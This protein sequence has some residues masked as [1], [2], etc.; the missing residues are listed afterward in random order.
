MGI[1]NDGHDRVSVKDGTVFCCFGE[2]TA[3]LFRD[4]AHSRF[5]RLR[6][7]GAV[8]MSCQCDHTEVSRSSFGADPQAV[9][10]RGHHNRIIRNHGFDAEFIG[11]GVS[12]DHNVIAKNTGFRS[13]R[14]DIVVF[15]DSHDNVVAGNTLTEVGGHP[16]YLGIW[17]R[18]D[19]DT[20][21]A[22]DHTAIRRNV[23]AGNAI[24]CPLSGR[25]E[26]PFAGDGIQ[27]DLGSTATL[28]IANRVFANEGDGID[29]EAVETR[30]IGN[31][32]NDNGDL[33]IEAVPGVFGRANRASANGNPLQC[34]NVVCR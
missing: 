27:I 13:R 5:S 6:V 15:G 26:A 8:A 3:I 31:V 29:V 12:G 22:P 24:C 19:P 34:L 7:V 32:A 30:L 10:V 14:S 11:V 16:G 33:G 1:L 25:D 4:S 21:A 18:R 9:G 17:I 2:G 23:V 20:G 28:A